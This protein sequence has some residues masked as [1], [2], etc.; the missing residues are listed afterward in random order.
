MV[1]PLLLLDFREGMRQ[2]M[3]DDILG[4]QFRLI[5]SRLDP[6]FGVM[7]LPPRNLDMEDIG[8]RHIGNMYLVPVLSLNL[9]QV[10][11][12][13]LVIFGRN[14]P[15]AEVEIQFSKRYGCRLDV[16][17]SINGCPYIR[18]DLFGFGHVE[19]CSKALYL[20]IDIAA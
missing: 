20:M 13:V 6:P 16:L 10:P 5:G 17:Q 7:L 1:Y 18:L 9:E 14:P 11:D 15:F 3:A 12:K 4:G 19:V 8:R 2:R